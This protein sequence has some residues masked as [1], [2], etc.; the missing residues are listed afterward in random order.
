MKFGG[1]VDEPVQI[2]GTVEVITDGDPD[3]PILMARRDLHTAENIL[4]PSLA[5]L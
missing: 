4:S 2:T 1:K 3:P 5:L